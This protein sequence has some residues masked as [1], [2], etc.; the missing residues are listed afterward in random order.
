M[1][2]LI[3]QD[4]T[5]Q[6][7]RDTSAANLGTGRVV[8]PGEV[9]RKAQSAQAR[10]RFFQVA[11]VV[12]LLG[13]LAYLALAW[14]QGTRCKVHLVNGL[15][16]P[17][18]VRLN[19]GEHALQPQSVTP[20]RLAEGEVEV[21]IADSS[22]PPETLSIATPFWSRPFASHTF[23][24]NPDRSAILQISTVTYVPRNAGGGAPPSR[25]EFTTGQT[26]QY[27]RDIDYPFEPV[28]ESIELDSGAKQTTRMALSVLGKEAPLPGHYLLSGRW[29][30][31]NPRR[32][33]TQARATG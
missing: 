15:D 30:I 24:I 2:P 14:I 33:E 1:G 11:P 5:F 22:I 23:V 27:F 32:P 3:R 20:V 26:L 7:L 10:R 13:V 4:A 28:P 6:R 25:P 18:T 21:E 17:Y 31:S 16:R 12:V 8:K 29:T 9:V 19:G